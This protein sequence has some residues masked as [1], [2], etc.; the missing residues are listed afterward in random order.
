MRANL[1]PLAVPQATLLTEYLEDG[2][3]KGQSLL[4]LDLERCTR[5]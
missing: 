2:L 5:L 4:V 1:E 3:F